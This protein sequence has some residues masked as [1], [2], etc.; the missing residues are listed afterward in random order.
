MDR[1]DLE[2]CS[3][4]C[5][6]DLTPLEDGDWVSYEDVAALEAENERLRAERDICAFMLVEGLQP[7][8][9]GDCESPWELDQHDGEGAV[10]F[11]TWREMLIAV[12]ESHLWWD[13]ADDLRR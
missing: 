6:A 2:C 3:G 1:Y 10:E 11:G 4:R 13:H 7:A 8:Q 12:A 5:C 9:N